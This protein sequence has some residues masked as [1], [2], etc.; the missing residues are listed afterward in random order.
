MLDKIGTL[1]LNDG[2]EYPLACNLNVL[3]LVQEQY[4]TTDKWT[5]LLSSE[6]INFKCLKWTFMQFIN[7]G[8]DIENEEKGTNRPFV[9]EKK[10]GR[11]IGQLEN[12]GMNQLFEI[13]KDS[14]PIKDPNETEDPNS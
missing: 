9:T 5:E 11:I 12:K 2:T 6:N 13:F 3:E 10:V 8:I 4:G 1:K 14:M 7:E